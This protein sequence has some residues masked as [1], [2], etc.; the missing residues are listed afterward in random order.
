VLPSI[1]A[2]ACLLLLPSS[3]PRRDTDGNPR[4]G[5]G[6]VR[7]AIA[8]WLAHVREEMQAWKSAC[9]RM[10]PGRGAAVALVGAD[11]N[12]GGSGWRLETVYSGFQAGREVLEVM[13]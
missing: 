8:A 13:W 5:N 4:A 7:A 10:P 11:P 12:G 1:S 6:V 3:I 9:A 2:S